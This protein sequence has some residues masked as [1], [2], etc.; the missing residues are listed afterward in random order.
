M[1]R[2]NDKRSPLAL[3]KN[4]GYPSGNNL[5]HNSLEAR[6]AAAVHDASRLFPIGAIERG[7]GGNCHLPSLL[8]AL[9]RKSIRT[10]EDV[11]PASNDGPRIPQGKQN[12]SAGSP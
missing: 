1:P 5:A 10:A 2:N 12:E 7:V 4:L 3:G 9:A 6:L 8:A 11:I